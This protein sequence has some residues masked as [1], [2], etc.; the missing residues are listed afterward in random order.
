MFNAYPWDYSILL[1]KL[2][3]IVFFALLR[4][5]SAVSEKALSST[6]FLI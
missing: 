4:E 6:H 5:K 3:E 2:P 1:Q